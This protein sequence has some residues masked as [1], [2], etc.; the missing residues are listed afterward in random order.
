MFF[1]LAVIT[2]II[3]VFKASITLTILGGM[4]YIMGMLEEILKAVKRDE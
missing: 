1:I 2:G 4:W 3:A